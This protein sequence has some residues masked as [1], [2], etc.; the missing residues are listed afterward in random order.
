MKRF[1]LIEL[2]V[3]IAIIAI[4]A[5][6]LLP[7]LG[8][9]RETAKKASCLGNLHQLGV[10]VNSY[11]GDFDGNTPHTFLNG[12]EWPDSLSCGGGSWS[13]G[14]FYGGLGLLHATAYVKGQ[15]GVFWCPSQRPESFSNQKIN[16][17]ILDVPG[18]VTYGS[19]SYRCSTGEPWGDADLGALRGLNLARA[20]GNQALAADSCIHPLLMMSPHLDLATGKG[21]YQI[22]HADGSVRTFLDASGQ[23]ANSFGQLGYDRSHFQGP[24]SH[25]Q[26]WL[27]LFD[28]N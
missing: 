8:K 25:V 12:C 5:S 27:N 13:G 1:T 4:L 17:P 11:A 9:A 2:L 20:S 28:H 19:Y 24:S 22:L 18:Q 16:L 26:L 3:V 23:I 7:A 6:M 10:A 15:S 21:S 14:M